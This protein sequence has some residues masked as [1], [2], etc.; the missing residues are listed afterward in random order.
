VGFLDIDRIDIEQKTNKD[1]KYSQNKIYKK[2]S[3]Q[4]SYIEEE[5]TTQ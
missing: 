1:T 2:R 5:Q 3:N 4:N